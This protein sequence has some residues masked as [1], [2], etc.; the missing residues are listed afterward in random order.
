MVTGTTI[1]LN[2]A[3]ELWTDPEHKSSSRPKGSQVVLPNRIAKPRIVCG[4]KELKR[5]D[6]SKMTSR[7]VLEHKVEAVLDRSGAR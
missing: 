6:F 5:H 1:A 4:L 2:T 7:K 3:A